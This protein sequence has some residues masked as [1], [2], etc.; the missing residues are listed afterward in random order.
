[1]TKYV[2]HYTLKGERRWDF[3]HLQS[4]SLG[5]AEAALI[6]LHGK[7]ERANI[8]DIRVTRAL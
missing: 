2:I 8:A 1:M 3:A 6:A 4:G 7:E 5:E